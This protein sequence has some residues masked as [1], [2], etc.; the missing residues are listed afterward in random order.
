MV[1][2]TE[3]K[4]EEARDTCA[5]KNTSALSLAPSLGWVQVQ[6]RAVIEMSG[7]YLGSHFS[8]FPLR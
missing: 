5:A 7:D 6:L 1:N 8:V 2:E 3:R 4:G